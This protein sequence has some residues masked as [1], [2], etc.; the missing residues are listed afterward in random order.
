M[1][2]L[3]SHLAKLYLGTTAIEC[4]NIEDQAEKLWLYK[5]YEDIKQTE[6]AADEKLD[7]ATEMLKSQTFDNFLA[8]RFQSVKRYGGGGGGAMV[9]FFVELF[10]KA[11]ADGVAD[12]VC[13]MAHRG[14]LNLM[15][16]LMQFPPVV[17]FR[18]ARILFLYL[19]AIL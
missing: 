17:M 10:R 15:T 14:R 12:I 9:G 6:L 7:L 16:G 2:S 11:N 4:E 1:S 13:G 8:T 19:T 5:K 18:N 3:S